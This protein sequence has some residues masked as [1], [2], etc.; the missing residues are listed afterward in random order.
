MNIFSGPPINSIS[1]TQE[2]H[3]QQR[4]KSSPKIIP[5]KRSLTKFNQSISGNFLPSI[6]KRKAFVGEREKKRTHPSRNPSRNH[7]EE[8]R[9]WPE[10]ETIPYIVGIVSSDPREN[11][12]NTGCEEKTEGGK[13]RCYLGGQRNYT[14]K[15]FRASKGA[16]IARRDDGAAERLNEI[17]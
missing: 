3:I 14:G 8:G 11:R 1:F 9:R 12:E 7:E 13:G 16:R 10:L 2:L 17:I 4:F 15:I 6:E 5:K